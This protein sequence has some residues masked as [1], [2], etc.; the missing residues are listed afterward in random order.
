VREILWLGDG[1]EGDDT[2]GHID[3]LTRFIGE[4]AVV[5][6]LEAD[7]SDPNHAPLQANLD[8]LRRLTI[9]GQPLEITTLPM[10]AKIVREDLRLPASY[11]NFY[12]ANQCV[13]LP[14]FADPNDAMAV[15]I[16]QRAFPTRRV[17]PIDCRELIWGLGA[18]H[19]LTQQQPVSG[20]GL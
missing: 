10:P 13:L 20:D 5:T 8:R 4:R 2:D 17:I 15:D 19:C 6:V 16:L 1:I 9:A 11:A 18:F 14:A 12:I 7:E 3:D